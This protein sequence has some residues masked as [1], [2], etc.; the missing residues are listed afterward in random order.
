M[1]IWKHFPIG[2]FPRELLACR[3]WI[4][5]TTRTKIVIKLVKDS[6]SSVADAFNWNPSFLGERRWNA[7]NKIESLWKSR[8]ARER[9]RAT[10]FAVRTEVVGSVCYPKKAELSCVSWNLGLLVWGAMWPSGVNSGGS[11]LWKFSKEKRCQDVQWYSEQ[12]FAVQLKVFHR[13][14]S[15]RAMIINSYAKF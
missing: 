9:E 2:A 11:S 4:P 7:P 3:H 5:V 10:G 15:F 13:C 8:R 6:V 14:L 1:K 12:K